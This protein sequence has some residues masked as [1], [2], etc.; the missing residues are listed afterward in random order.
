MW[1]CLL[2]ALQDV[3]VPE[4]TRF[5]F[6]RERIGHKLTAEATLANVLAQDLADVRVV[7]VYYDGAGELRRSKPVTVSRIASGASASFVLEAE[8]V[9]NFSRYEVWVEYAGRARVYV[10][11]DPKR[12]P[13][14]KRAEPPKL[15]AF[16]ANDTPPSKFPGEAV[17]AL[18]VRNTG[19]LEAQEP[20]A[21]LSFED[22]GGAVV[23]R[24]R[25]RLDAQI[26]PATEDTFILQVPAVPEYAAMKAS[27]A[28]LAAEGLTL[29]EPA[30]DAK[31]VV[32]RE[33]RIVRLTDGSARVT[34]VLH[35]PTADPVERIVV[36][37]KLGK[38]QAQVAVPGRLKGGARRP[39]EH[40]AP[41]CPPFESAGYGLAYADAEGEG[42]DAPA[43]A[44]PAVKRLGTQPIEIRGP[45]L[46]DA[47]GAK[48]QDAKPDEKPAAMTVAL[49]GL[50]V[51][52]GGSTKFGNKVTGDTF[53]MKVAFTG[54]DGRPAK[55][56]GTFEMTLYN[57]EQPYKKIQRIVNASHWK[58]DASKINELNVADNT[59]AADPKTG[60]LW[61]ALVR[62]DTPGSFQ[63]RADIKL[64]L[65]GQGSWTWKGVAE[66]FEVAGKGPDPKK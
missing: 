39:F 43:G 3:K 18:T 26:R 45:K 46:P 42:V 64:T 37:L 7:A 22:S 1:L 66:K 52:Q 50:M 25:V 65:S 56:T 5:E 19:E 2:L 11:T 59:I 33:C 6:A 54:A 27:L 51:V 29:A 20:T 17:V 21:I 16:A 4:F 49:T 32:V 63:P 24:V 44:A 13:Q 15:Y 48:G 62:T 57:G 40:Y 36:T 58:I 12:P 8:Q 61:V 35:N 30:A 28:W 41:D 38:V 47:P 55:P 34:G 23:H 10:G 60:E 31:E 9:P 14:P 53:L